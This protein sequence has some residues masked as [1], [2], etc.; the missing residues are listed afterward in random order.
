MLAKPPSF[1]LF[2]D[3]KS[4]FPSLFKSAINTLYEVLPPPKL[5]VTPEMELTV[6]KVPEEITPEVEVFLNT[7]GTPAVE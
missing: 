2:D 4:I 5:G 3:A 7:C 6:A 1:A